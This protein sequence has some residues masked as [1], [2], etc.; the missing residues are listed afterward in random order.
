M[1]ELAPAPVAEPPQGTAQEEML[2]TG[3]ITDTKKEA[4]GEQMCSLTDRVVKGAGDCCV[5]KSARKSG[6]P[7]TTKE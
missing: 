5:P 4:E 7:G 2:A 3:K 6:V 1:G